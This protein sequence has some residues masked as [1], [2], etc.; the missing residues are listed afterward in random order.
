MTVQQRLHLCL[1]DIHQCSTSYMHLYVQWET[2]ESKNAQV[3]IITMNSVRG[4]KAL[5]K[6]DEQRIA[7]K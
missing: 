5:E 4:K 3:S 6:H 7:I 1:L 2:E